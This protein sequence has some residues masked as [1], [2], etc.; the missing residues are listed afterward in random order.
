MARIVDTTILG[1]SI[2]P[3]P[4]P[5]TAPVSP[6]GSRPALSTRLRGITTLARSTAGAGRPVGG[7]GAGGTGVGAGA[8]TKWRRFATMG[9]GVEKGPYFGNRLMWIYL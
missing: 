9:L 1:T 5:C 8:V 3:N 2:G 6:Q 7:A 4:T